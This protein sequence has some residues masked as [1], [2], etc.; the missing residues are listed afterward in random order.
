[1]FVIPKFRKKTDD[2]SGTGV[3]GDYLACTEIGPTTQILSIKES[4]RTKEL[5]IT[6]SQTNTEQCGAVKASLHINSVNGDTNCAGNPNY[7]YFSVDVPCPLATT[8][9]PTTTVP[10]TTVPTTT[11]DTTTTTNPTTSIVTTSVT[12]TVPTTITTT[13]A[14][15]VPT[16]IATTTV[17]PGPPPSTTTTEA[18]GASTSVETT[19]VEETTTT[20][21]AG[22]L[23]GGFLGF[24]DE[25]GEVTLL[26]IALI[27]LLL[28]ILLTLLYFL[29]FGRKKK[30]KWFK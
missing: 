29:M 22:L 18:F 3:F 13:I 26:G 27:I 21:D 15:T 20:T 6:A 23:T 11:V 2:G 4:E 10:T 30:K 16:T 8:T 7:A 1:M 17:S 14:T 25:N 28:I 19:I 5:S 12:T 9:V 24:I